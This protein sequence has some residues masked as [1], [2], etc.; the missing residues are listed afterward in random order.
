MGA[1]CPPLNSCETSLCDVPNPL[2]TQRPAA[3]TAG[4]PIMTGRFRHGLCTRQANAPPR[5]N[6]AAACPRFCTRTLQACLRHRLRLRPSLHKLRSS[7]LPTTQ[8]HACACAATHASGKR[9]QHPAPEIPGVFTRQL[10]TNLQVARHRSATAV[11][12]RVTCSTTG[13]PR[14]HPR[15]G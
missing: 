5:A 3:S 12:P 13:A 1:A 8:R 11:T 7:P 4:T 14:L 15:A 9:F 10:H 2:G 6:P